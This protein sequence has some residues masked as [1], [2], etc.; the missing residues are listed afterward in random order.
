[1]CTQNIVYLYEFEY[2]YTRLTF[3]S[4]LYLKLYEESKC[5]AKT[6]LVLGI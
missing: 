5:K 6:I 3:N 4:L 2:D 1:M